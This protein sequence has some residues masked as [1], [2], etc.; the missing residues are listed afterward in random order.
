MA[1]LINDECINCSA[2]VDEC[3]RGAIYEADPHFLID[4]AKCTECEEEGESK[5]KVVCPVDCIVAMS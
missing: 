4:A 5:C 1:L 2:C 3:P